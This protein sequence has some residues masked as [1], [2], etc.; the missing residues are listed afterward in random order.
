MRECTTMVQPIRKSRA[1][2]VLVVL[3]FTLFSTQ[4]ALAQFADKWGKWG[5]SPEDYEVGGN[6]TVA[7]GTAGAG[8]IQSKVPE[9]KDFGTLSNSVKPEPFIGKRVRLSGFIKGENVDQWV[10]FWMRV[11]G[12]NGHGVSFDNMEYRP[13]VG[14]TDWNKYDVVLDVPTSSVNIALGVLLVG[15]G[16]AWVDG[17]RFETV[18]TDVPVT[19]IDPFADYYAG[20]FSDAAKVFQMATRNNPKDLYSRLFYFLSL[21]RSGQAKE[22]QGYMTKVADDLKEEK[23]VVPVFHFYAGKLSE[24]ELLKA[25]VNKDSTVD[26]QQKCEAYFYIGM[27]YLL[28]MD[29]TQLSDHP[30]S[31]RAKEYFEKCVATGQTDF[32]EYRGA[33]TELGKSGK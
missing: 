16:K 17:V 3:I 19:P 26:N 21:Y 25:A 18:G 20:K 4:A 6:P 1:P 33:Q 32:F 24:D 13:I 29:K 14:T 10:G 11:D 8:Y 9:P 28:D 15:K 22:A 27:A 30:G 5:K 12:P 23:W 7:H 31:A 2:M